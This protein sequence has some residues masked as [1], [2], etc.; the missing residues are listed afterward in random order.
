MAIMDV[1]RANGAKN[2]GIVLD[3]VNPLEQTTPAS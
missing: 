3:W 2:I 1:V